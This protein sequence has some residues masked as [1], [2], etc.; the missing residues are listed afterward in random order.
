MKLLVVTPT[1]GTSPWLGETVQSVR[2]HAPESAHALVAPSETL[3]VLGAAYPWCR[4]V[5]EGEGARGMY[6]AINRALEADAEWE[7]FT[8][9]N[10]DDLLLPGISQA[11]AGAAAPAR[12]RQA[13]LVYGRVALIDSR[14]RGLGHIP[15]SR[16]PCG[17]RPLY[18]ERLEPVY[19]H[20]TIV[21]RGAWERYGGFDESFRL[22]G[23]SEY[24]ARLCVAGVPAVYVP[25]TVAAF[26]LRPGQLTKRRAEMQAERLRVDEK[27]GLLHG[28]GR[29]ERLWARLVFRLTNAPV[30]AGRIARHGFKR[31]DDVLAGSE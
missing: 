20:G 8:Y 4:L 9:L 25:A 28:P 13:A 16:R 22:C 30:Y 27:L 18:A 29:I 21:T 23:D 6:A 2:R 7:A 17:N 24:L 26:R 10:D 5:D 14:G 1:L 31:F 12:E 19:Q 11:Q 15:I 3:S